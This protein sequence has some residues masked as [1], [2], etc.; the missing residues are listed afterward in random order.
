MAREINGIPIDDDIPEPRPVSRENKYIPV[1]K[2]MRKGESFVV[3]GLLEANRAR[4]ATRIPSRD[5]GKQFT[6]RREKDG[7]FRVWRVK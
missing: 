3:F 2:R 7:F 1:I 5:E 4:N 6:I